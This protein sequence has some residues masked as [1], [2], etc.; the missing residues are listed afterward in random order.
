MSRKAFL[1][2]ILAVSTGLFGQKSGGAGT[3]STGAGAGSAGVGTAGSGTTAGTGINTSASQ[4]GSPTT[5]GAVGGLSGQ[6]AAGPINTPSANQTGTPTQS[7]AMA[8]PGGTTGST[9]ANPDNLNNGTT[10]NNGLN[11]AVGGGSFGAPILSTP[12]ASFAAPAPTAGISDAGR[13]GISSNTN[14]NPG[15]PST[16]ENS[17]VVYT[18]GAP[19]N[20][21]AVNMS[22]AAAGGRLIN[23]MGPS[24]YSDTISGSGQAVSLGEVAAQFKAAKGAVNAR[25]LTNDDV[26][27]MVS[28]KTGVTMAK[29]MPPLGPGAT[30]QQS[31]TAQTQA[32]STQAPSTQTAQSSASTT[33]QNQNAAGTQ[34]GTPP[35]ATQGQ[36]AGSEATAGNS[37]TPEI[38]QNQQSNDARGKSKLPATSTLLPL[39]GL[40]GLLSGGFGLWFRKWRR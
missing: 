21:P 38:N 30:P 40:L 37:T 19:V 1:V 3:G 13:A 31:T 16:L 23:D 32:P 11:G 39:F 5:Q 27:K 15:V 6:A 17:T 20:P 33:Q 29:N 36:A 22:G 35:P 28:D 7:G 25:T 24:F 26:Q 18:N 9:Q 8:G 2:A 4:A 12:G 10:S 34:A 14:V